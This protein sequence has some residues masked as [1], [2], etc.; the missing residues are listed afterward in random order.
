MKLLINK[1][2]LVYPPITNQEGAWL[3]NVPEVRDFVK[4]S[5]LYMIGH[6][7]ELKFINEQF[8]SE[9]RGIIQFQ[10]ATATHKSPIIQISLYHCL[11]DIED[12]ISIELGEKL[13]RIKDSQGNVLQ[14][15]TPDILLYR[16]WK[17]QL[18]IRIIDDTEFNYRDFTRYELYYV[19]I[20]KNNDSFSRLFD[21]SHHARLKI[22]T[23]EYPKSSGRLTDELLI[24][25]FQI[26]KLN[27]NIFDRIEDIDEQINYHTEDE[28][29]I[30]ADAEKAFIKLLETKYNEVKYKN[31][32]NGD[33]GL[34]SEGLD[35][36]CFYIG[37]DITFYTTKGDFIGASDVHDHADMIFVESEVAKVVKETIDS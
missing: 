3:W 31:Y 34:Y 4:G 15:Y 24:F 1:L 33:D 19:G 12:E 21:E 22:L 25:M 17:N 9:G 13:F 29:A 26:D 37:E 8:I 28:I 36:Y 18:T 20:S 35:R 23:N 2:N 14:W 27:I 10:L 30:I 7:E 11:P 5:K 16:Y 32:P 6:R